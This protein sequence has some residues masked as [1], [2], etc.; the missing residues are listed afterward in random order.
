[1]SLLDSFIEVLASDPLNAKTHSEIMLHNLSL[2]GLWQGAS[3]KTLVESTHTPAA[4][5]ERYCNHD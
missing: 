2:T 4:K 5:Q 3:E 1:M